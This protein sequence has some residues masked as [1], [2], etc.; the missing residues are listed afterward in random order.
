M[1]KLLI[2]DDEMQ[3]LKLTG[4]LLQQ[5][6]Y[7]ILAAQSGVRALVKAKTEKPDLVILDVMLPD[8]DGYEICRRLRADPATANL[9]VIMLTAKTLM[10]DKV[11]GFQAGADDYMTK[12][13][14]PDELIARVEALL[15]R[16]GRQPTRARAKVLGFLG[17]KGG[18]GT[19]ALAV[20]V[21]VALAQGPARDQRIVLADVQSGMAT[22]SLQLGLRRHGGLA[23]LLEKPAGRIEAKM[24]DVQLEEH[25]TG[26]R[27]LSGQIEPAGVAI[28]MSRAHAEVILRHLG[29]M[30]DYLLLDL[31]TGLGE[32]NRR[33]LPDCHRI[34]VVI[35]PQ[36]VAIVLARALLEQMTTSLNLARH[37][38]SVVLVNKSPGASF[39]KSGVEKSL[40]YELAGTIP[41]AP[42]LAFH[43]A[44]QGVPIVLEQPD[45]LVARQ[46]RTIAERL[47]DV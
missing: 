44:A 36:H 25:E 22:T 9:P 10:K 31:G 11:D 16:S 21:A 20:N 29:T 28:P 23:Q 47:L 38:I 24:V 18:V 19:T 46:I 39:T 4:L 8:M 5:H 33:I 37:K 17:S 27:I 3:T 42:E 41:S 6:G 7:E 26:V 34:V 32:V 15:L 13:V 45:S 2:V 35:E 40:Q 1:T 12:P 14:H 30:A 43:A